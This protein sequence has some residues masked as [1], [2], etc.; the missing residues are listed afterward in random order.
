VRMSDRCTRARTKGRWR[1]TSKGTA[2]TLDSLATIDSERQDEVIKKGP[3]PFRT[4][5]MVVDARSPAQ[6]PKASVPSPHGSR[7]PT[8]GDGEPRA[9][10]TADSSA[11]VDVAMTRGD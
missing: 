3:Q 2:L 4:A 11:S 8:A 7:R 9:S 1:Y 5:T 10:R 6:P